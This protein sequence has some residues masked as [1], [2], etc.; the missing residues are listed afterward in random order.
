MPEETLYGSLIEM[1][2]L[3]GKRVLVTGGA[4]RNWLLIVEALLVPGARR[5]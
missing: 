4:L 3:H 2:G 5:L 1:F